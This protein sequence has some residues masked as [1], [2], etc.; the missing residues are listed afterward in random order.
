MFMVHLERRHLSGPEISRPATLTATMEHTMS[1]DDVVGV[2]EYEGAAAGWGA[3]KAVADAVRGQMAIVKETRGL[4]SMNHPHGFD[5]PGCA[6]PDPKHTSSFEFC[7]NGA[8][9]VSF[10]LT[11]RRVTPEFFAAHT[12]SELER[13]SDYWLEEQ[14]RLTEPMRY[15][16]TSDHYEPISW[17]DAFA[18]IG[19]HLRA[20]ES[21]DRADFYTSGRA[22]NEAAFLYQIFVRRFGTNNF[23]DCSNMCH[24]ATSVGLPESIGIG[25]GTV[26]LE[27]FDKTDAIFVIGQNP[28]TNSPRMM[29]PLREASRRGV[30]IVAM[31]P[32]RERALERFAAPQD[33]IEMLTFS[34]TQIAS[35]YCQVRVGGDVAVLK[36]IMKVVLDA[37]EDAVRAGRE[38]VLDLAFIERH[39]DGFEA[40]AADLRATSWDDILR[41]SG[42]ER[43]QIERVA[44]IYMRSKSVI[45]CF[46]M[47]IT[48]HRRG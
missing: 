32:L 44:Q 11:K 8:K 30:P 22:S 35:E 48:Q 15:N 36:G 4:L 23:P 47:G 45:I 21:P 26:L 1:E 14:G 46:G 18:L 43:A 5:C 20:L 17:D 42:L 34:S 25:K 13:Q 10:E 39:T 31:N 7:E 6:W 29:T 28:G 24:E 33:P 37:H 40:L 3:L 19:T 9:A 2:G 27:D 16:R 38:P 12:V 41:V